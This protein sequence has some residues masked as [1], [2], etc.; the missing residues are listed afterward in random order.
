[1]SSTIRGALDRSAGCSIIEEFET[2]KLNL[3]FKEKQYI[4]DLKLTRTL[5]IRY[6]PIPPQLAP[7]LKSDGGCSVV[8]KRCVSS[9]LRPTPPR[10]C[11]STRF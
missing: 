3:R 9:S 7:Y 5:E 4:N 11:R 8:F 2:G 6:P 1:M 10:V